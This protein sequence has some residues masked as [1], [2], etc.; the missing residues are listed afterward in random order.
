MECGVIVCDHYIAAT[1]LKEFDDKQRE[2]K[3]RVDGCVSNMLNNLVLKDL[4]TRCS[5]FN[6]YVSC[7][8]TLFN[9]KI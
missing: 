4:Q 1:N 8:T 6:L 9:K 7:Q 3:S 2:Y 5:D